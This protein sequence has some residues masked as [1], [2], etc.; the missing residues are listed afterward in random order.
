[1]TFL[2][3]SIYILA[4]AFGPQ[5]NTHRRIVANN[6]K[7]LYLA[8]YP[9]INRWKM[10]NM[11]HD[12]GKSNQN[13]NLRLTDVKVN[14]CHSSCEIRGHWRRIYWGNIRLWKYLN[15][16]IRCKQKTFT[17]HN[18]FSISICVPCTRYKRS[19]PYVSVFVLFV[20]LFLYIC[21]VLLCIYV[22]K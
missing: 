7:S 11:E 4:L 16:S 17:A 18:S 2:T 22:K 5:I 15:H 9:N 19:V 10:S 14:G 20:V 6:E 13:I 12:I 8:I 21:F 3:S 1:M